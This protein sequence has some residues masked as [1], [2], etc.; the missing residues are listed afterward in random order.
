MKTKFYF[1][2]KNTKALVNNEIEFKK[3]ALKN[4]WTEDEVGEHLKETLTT[5]IDS[6]YDF[7][8]RYDKLLEYFKPLDEVTL[9]TLSGAEL[10]RKLSDENKVK[11]IKS[12]YESF[13]ILG[14]D[15][16]L[17]MIYNCINDIK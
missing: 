7:D 3:Q 2:F 16:A 17:K 1:K 15:T 11:F 5:F 6:G 4:G 14:R 12:V 8:K 13:D 10:E 9:D